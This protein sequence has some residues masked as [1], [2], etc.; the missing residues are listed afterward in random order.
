MFYV[1]KGKNAKA[2]QNSLDSSHK[3]D[4]GDDIEEKLQPR[5]NPR[6][7]K[8]DEEMIE[9]NSLEKNPCVYDQIDPDE[10]LGKLDINEMDLPNC[11]DAWNEA[12]LGDRL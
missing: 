4:T 7:I 8:V 12:R 11:Y 3:P 5:K 9:T 6:R 2:T 1:E 10:I